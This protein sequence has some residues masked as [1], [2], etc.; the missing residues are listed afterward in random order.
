VYGG[1]GNIARQ[2]A[3]ERQSEPEAR[4]DIQAP[5][6]GL[7]DRLLGPP[8]LLPPRRRGREADCQR[9]HSHAEA[10]THAPMIASVPTERNFAIARA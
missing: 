4:P 3:A 5:P 9:N 1:E 8:R 7:Q 2:D 10:A 6:R